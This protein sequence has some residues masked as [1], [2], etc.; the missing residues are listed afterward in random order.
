MPVQ[1]AYSAA[2]I[3]NNAFSVTAVH[4]CKRNRSVSRGNNVS[5]VCCADVKSRMKL[6]CFVNGMN[7]VAVIACY[8]SA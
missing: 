4:R 5:S 3:D 7:S 2:V 8:S 6:F 1:R